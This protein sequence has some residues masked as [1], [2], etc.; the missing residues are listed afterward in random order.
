MM[1]SKEMSEHVLALSKLSHIH[2]H[3]PT[4][5]ASMRPE[6]RKHLRILDGIALM[7]V[8]ESKGDVA[9][10]T[11]SQ[12]TDSIQVHYAKNS[13]S[14]GD[15]REYINSIVCHLSDNRHLPLG[16]LSYHLSMIIIKKCLKKVRHRAMKLIR[17]LKDVS[18]DKLDNE[19]NIVQSLFPNGQLSSKDK[20]T[21]VDYVKGLDT[22]STQD[23]Q[24][25]SHQIDPLFWVIFESYNIGI[26]N[27]FPPSRPSHR[28]LMC[29]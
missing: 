19:E 14:K 24:Q 25:L 11:I 21:L 16:D 28:G 18:N 23:V 4:R 12:S 10:V 6:D 5:P 15:L 22:L 26:V 3:A 17:S 7:L 29:V 27:L 13:A 9:A 8:T 1:N 20:S 2:E